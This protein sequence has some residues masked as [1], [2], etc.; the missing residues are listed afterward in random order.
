[1][2]SLGAVFKVSEFQFRHA[3]FSGVPKAYQHMIFKHLLKK[4]VTVPAT[5]H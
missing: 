4:T 2:H 5:V 3:S 1:M